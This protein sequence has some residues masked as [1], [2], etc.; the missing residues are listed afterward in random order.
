MEKNSLNNILLV[1]IVIILIA[2]ILFNMSNINN[3]KGGPVTTVIYPNNNLS[4]IP[5][6]GRN[7]DRRGDIKK[8]N[9]TD[10]ISLLKPYQKENVR[11]FTNVKPIKQFNKEFFDF[12]DKFTNENSSMRP[13]TV[14]KIIDYRLNEGTSDSFKGKKIKDIYDELVNDNDGLDDFGP[15]NNNN[16][17]NF[18]IHPYDSSNTSFMPALQSII[19]M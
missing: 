2:W 15:V 7:N 9:N 6:Y 12:R 3:N 18:G 10:K 1:I 4:T 19:P 17:S 14:D 8:K 16:L 11:P 5:I 13:D